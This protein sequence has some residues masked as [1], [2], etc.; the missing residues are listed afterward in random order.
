MLIVLAA[1]PILLLLILLTVFRWSGQR[2][3]ITSWL[4]ALLVAALFFGLTP[5]VFLVSQLKGLI[6]SLYVLAVLW[7]A[8][9]LY[10]LNV[11]VGGIRALTTWLSELLP[12]RSLLIVLLA[13]PFC[14]ILE[15]VAG[16]GLPI[17][18]SAP[19]LVS[20]GV[21]PF[22]AVVA[23]AIGHTWSVTFGNMGVVL[24]SLVTLSGY[25]ETEIIP[26]A[27]LMMGVACIL[28]GLAVAHVLE[29]LRHWKLVLLLGAVMALIQF[30][31]A[32]IG[33]SPLASFVASL[34]G[35]VIGIL[36]GRKGSAEKVA[37]PR[38]LWAT[39]GSYGLLTLISLA[40]FINGPLRDWVFPILWRAPFPEV[41][42]R[43]GFVT[44]A[45]F[46]QTFR[47]LAHPGTL[48]LL[49]I[50]ISLL[51]FRR[52][53]L[54]EKGAM[55][56]AA[57]ATFR[58]A[59]PATVGVIATVGVSVMLD[60]TGMIQLLARTISDWTGRAF[61][62]ISP[63][64]GMVGAFATGSNTN[65]NVLFVSLQKQVA[66]FI[67][68]LPLILIATQT[69]GG[70][71]GSMIAPAK[72]MIGSSNVGLIGQEGRILRRTLP[73]ALS[74]GVILGLVALALSLL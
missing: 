38:V 44:P 10:N 23:P 4:A 64:I 33:L 63:L 34:G 58:S 65:S 43:T 15:G 36:L 7:P 32:W 35:L 52:F 29:Q 70:S 14:S 47:W 17:A 72:L 18:I 49:T 11:Q 55:S 3:G 54:L 19:M 28:C 6:F 74:I 56:N 31:M 53:N 68:I 66:G 69:A 22:L 9:L 13:W 42:T 37:A 71:L 24:Q 73:Y 48:I 2:A 26:Y 5:R 62:V 1:L 57:R 61:P 45:G 21:P 16:F 30:L 51:A 27:A 60:H 46:G 12:D 8:L 41:V 40:I 20:L 39:L 59:F 25:T 67:G 50:G